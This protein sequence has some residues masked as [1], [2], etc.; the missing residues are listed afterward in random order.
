MN[1]IG[2]QAPW[3]LFARKVGKIFENDEEVNVVY[4]DNEKEIK[5]FVSNA[6]KADA[7]SQI[8]PLEKTFGNI[9]V[10][11]I[12]VP[13]NNETLIDIYKRAFNGNPAIDRI[14]TATNLFED[15]GAYVIFKPEV[16]QYFA[17]DINDFYGNEST[18]YEDI[19]REIFEQIPQVHFCTD[20]VD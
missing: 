6:L 17:D 3:I 4:D 15:N 7:L 9:V 8:L 2:L 10:K 11:I 20:L 5:L 13:E 14:E 19:A 12:V 1:K 18:L 16:V